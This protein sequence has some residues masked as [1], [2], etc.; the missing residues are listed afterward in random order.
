[1]RI[2]NAGVKEYKMALRR[3][4][5]ECKLTDELLPNNVTVL[6]YS[7]RSICWYVLM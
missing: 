3:N 4:C 5:R 6:R 2:N 7:K 1:M